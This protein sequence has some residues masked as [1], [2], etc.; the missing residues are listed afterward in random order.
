[1]K[2]LAK[3]MAV[4]LALCICLSA[5]AGTASVT[6]DTSNGNTA[7]DSSKTN[8]DAATNGTEESTENYW[9]MLDSVSDTSE[10]PDWT[11]ET[12]EVNYW[13]AAGQSSSYTDLPSADDVTLKEFERVTGV[14]FLNDE[15]ID[16]G[17]DSYGAKLPMVLASN[18][19]PTM[20]VGY[21]MDNQLKELY[22]NGYLADLS[23]YFTDGSLSH[24][25]KYFPLDAFEN[26]LYAH[27]KADDGAYF[28]I[29]ADS[30]VIDRYYATGYYPD[31]LDPE[32]Y[33]MYG[34]NPIS[35]SGHSASNC[36]YVRDDV[37]KALY[38]DAMTEADIQEKYLENGSFTKDEIFDLN[39]MSAEDYFKL[40]R[41]IQTVVAD[42]TYTGLDGKAVEVTYG[43]HTDT[44]NWDWMMGLHSLL[45]GYNAQTD[46]FSVVK[47]NSESA[48]NCL[49][50]SIDNED[51]MGYMA[52]L[53]KLVQA[54]VISQNS[55]VDNSAAFTEKMMNGHYAVIYGN[56][57]AQAAGSSDITGDG[58]AYRPVWVNVPMNKT[59]G[60]VASAQSCMSISI[61]NGDLTSEQLT[62][63]V[64]ALD[65]L[66][67]DVGVNNMY[68]GPASAG[69][70]TVDD[71]GNR[72]YTNEDVKAEML[73]GADNG[74]CAKYGIVK[75][76]N[77]GQPWMLIAMAN[78]G[79]NLL[80]PKYLAAGSAERDAARADYYFNPGTLSGYSK[81]ENTIMLNAN[82]T[83]YSYGAANVEALAEFWNARPGFE[84]QM[85]KVICA[86]NEDEYN[87]QFQVLV[88]YATENGLTDESLKTFTDLFV[89]ANGDLLNEY[90][91]VK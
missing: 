45:S 71:N 33:S 50:W 26:N 36:I 42:G 9:D 79:S 11:G 21:D 65:Y 80:K 68:W 59:Y 77:P 54:D 40:L 78:P 76:G 63:L 60:G 8:S 57:I 16:N 20:I 41:D 15:C 3:I 12:L 23:Q 25:L 49:E 55:L 88:D 35:W 62:Q 69:L 13:W 19:L 73:E 66:Y 44:D 82:A 52:E 90:G 43:P 56:S 28:R 51:Y 30:N 83:V 31:N 24:M 29:P 17:G 10:L 37:L 47:F 64:H 58:W 14:R 91:I 61:F 74:A 53:N 39:L 86:A 81:A 4:L 89:A 22:D 87:K 48:D 46:Y 5:C 67:S 85:K 27:M 72:Y 34:N 38:P 18:D 1:M 6:E 84:N 7:S 2:K 32:Y 70:Y 75:D